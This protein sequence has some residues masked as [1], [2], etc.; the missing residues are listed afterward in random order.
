M[1]D[2]HFAW[3]RKRIVLEHFDFGLKEFSAAI[4]SA[5]ENTAAV[6]LIEVGTTGIAGLD[7][8]SANDSI[9]TMIPVPYDLNPYHDIGFRI[10][11]TGNPASAAGAALFTIWAQIILEGAALVGTTQ[12][13][14]TIVGNDTYGDNVGTGTATAWCSQFTKRGIMTSTEK[15]TV[16]RDQIEKGAAMCI[17]I[18][19]TVLTNMT[20]TVFQSLIIDYV[21][22]RCVGDH[23]GIDRPLRA[24]A[25]A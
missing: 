19:T 11:Y 18:D 16:T 5:A 14:K 4:G 25:R 21:P 15:F 12:T 17:W 6:P 10:R 23:Q 9:S 13:L 3:M 7:M 1:Q 2:N 24:D 20:T 8:T 22:Q